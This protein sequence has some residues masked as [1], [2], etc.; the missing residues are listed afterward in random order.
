M[1]ALNAS[2][3]TECVLCHDV[4]E[5]CQHLFFQCPYSSEVW[6]SLV[7]GILKYRFTTDWNAIMAMALIQFILTLKCFLS[8]T[9]FRLQFTV[10]GGRGGMEKNQKMLSL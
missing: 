10:F 4:Q 1:Q 9:R 3:N 2:I 6:K 8:D 5:T 7:K